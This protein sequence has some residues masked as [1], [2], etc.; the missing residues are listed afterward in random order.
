LETEQLIR[1]GSQ[2]RGRR[3]GTENVALIV[4]FGEAARI[5]LAQRGQRIDA[6]KRQRAMLIEQLR[7]AFPNIMING[8]DD[9]VS[10]NITSISFPSSA[11][12]IDGEALLYSLDLE[13]LAVSSGSACTAGSIEPSH[14]MRALGH[15][16][17]TAAATLRVSFGA[18]TKDEEIIEGKE[19][20][21]RT[22]QRM[23]AL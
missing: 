3:G 20:L 7:G 11:Y 19:I 15:D 6:W 21:V 10:P 5:A 1:G 17:S 8:S 9:A 13:G 4:G 23:L 14:V 22:V 16:T 12:T 2:E 18:Q